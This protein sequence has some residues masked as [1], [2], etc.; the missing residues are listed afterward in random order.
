M[1]EAAPITDPEPG[2]R[3][4]LAETDDLERRLREA[5]GETL[6]GLVREHAA[7][8]GV[9]EAR[10]VL[11]NPFADRE[12]IEVLI[13]LPRLLSAHEVRSAL[14]R[15][16]RTPQHHA[17]R[18]VSGL[19]WRELMTVGNDPR[20]PPAV[21]RA[22]ARALHARLPGLALGEKISLGR[23][24]APGV[25]AELRRDPNPRVIEAVL[26]NPRVSEGVLMPLVQDERAEPAVLRVVAGHPR[27]GARYEIRLALVRNRRLPVQIA[28]RLLPLLKK[29]DLR[30]VAREPKVRAAVRRRAQILCGEPLGAI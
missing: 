16:P 5:D 11:L 12:V 14:A 30:S 21:R 13:D 28:L 4:A 29:A 6:L 25:L 8:I 23:R 20:V 15:H 18:F 1:S 7:R 17:L 27:W 2:R 22:A 19:Y 24:A 26:E 9:P 10:Q 3:R